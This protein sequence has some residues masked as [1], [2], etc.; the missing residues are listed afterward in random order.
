MAKSTKRRMAKKA[1][2]EVEVE[3]E[4]SSGFREGYEAIRLDAPAPEDLVGKFVC[5]KHNDM[6]AKTTSLKTQVGDGSSDVS[7]DLY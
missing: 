1:K 5:I 3:K 7:K 6:W 2:E 4:T